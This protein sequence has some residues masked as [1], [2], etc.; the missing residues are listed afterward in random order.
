VVVTGISKF[1]RSKG[2][3]YPEA[4]LRVASLGLSKILAAL[5]EEIEEGVKEVVEIDAEVLERNSSKEAE[6]ESKKVGKKVHEREAEGSKSGTAAKEKK[7]DNCV[8]V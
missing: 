5:P 7:G 3:P 2:I 8:I 4:I 6:E 1:A